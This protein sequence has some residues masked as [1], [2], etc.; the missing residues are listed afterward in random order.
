MDTGI[1]VTWGGHS[2]ALVGLGEDRFLTDPVFSRRVGP[3]ARKAPPGIDPRD[4]PR[5]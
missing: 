4:L 3:V 1:S 5:L 2:T